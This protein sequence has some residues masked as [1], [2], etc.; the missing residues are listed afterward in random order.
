[1]TQVVRRRVRPAEARK[2][3]AGDLVEG[4]SK[5][6]LDAKRVTWPSAR[7]R[8]DPVLF[9]REVLGIEPW[10]KQVEIIE[11]L[12]TSKR[13]AVKS[14]HKIGK[15]SLAVG[16]ALWFYASFDDA[17]VKLT[18]TTARQV[19]DIL[20]RELRKVLGASGICVDCRRE[21]VDRK[22]RRDAGERGPAVEPIEK[23]CPHSAELDGKI[24][25]RAGTGLKASDFREITGAT[26]KQPEAVAGISGPAMLYIVDEASGVPDS[27]FE[28]MEGNRAAGAWMLMLSNPTRTIGEF[29][30]AFNRKA[31]FY[32]LFSVSSEETPNVIHGPNDP[33]AIPGLAGREWVEE[34]RREWGENSAQFKVRV[35]GEFPTGE[36]G[37]IFSVDTIVAAEANWED[38]D[39][40]SDGRLWLGVDPAGE[41]GKGDE[42]AIAVR[43]A[44][45]IFAV[46]AKLG[47]TPDDHVAWALDMIDAYAE[48]R[49][50]REIPVV[51]LDAEG[52]VGARVLGAF[53]AHL[54]Q[55]RKKPFALVTVRASDK[56]N[57]PRIYGL[58]R[59]D[60]AANF[61]AWLIDH[62]ARK[63]EGRVVGAIPT[64]AKLSAEMHFFEWEELG[65]GRLKLVPRKADLRKSDM[66]GRSPDRYDACALS[67]WEPARFRDG[68][69]PPPEEEDEE[70]FAEATFDPYHNP[71]AR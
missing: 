70:E 67:V 33:R 19:E 8:E 51:V 68:G 31:E 5:Q 12:L 43:R 62:D 55:Q 6:L 24:G 9:F 7:W 66:L 42:A 65:N 37:K 21:N 53:L 11:S 3:F 38:P 52:A 1:M 49:D 35:K 58:R 71:F 2:T 57:N 44:K 17:R 59:D 22:R 18:S 14:G 60:L 23:P 46:H 27:L 64:D 54:D 61:E 10:S 26:A 41:S 4:L 48:P 28:A 40:E 15:S 56:S 29:F 16:I 63:G 25:E 36:D 34:K 39:T 69:A 47:L 20:W 32:T 13:V 45:K 50:E 30:D